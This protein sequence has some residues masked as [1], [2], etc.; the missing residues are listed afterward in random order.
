MPRR[1]GRVA[2]GPG[3]AKRFT[4]QRFAGESEDPREA[5]CW[6]LTLECGIR[7]TEAKLAWLED[8]IARIEK[9]EMPPVR[10]GKVTK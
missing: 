1:A 4:A 9:G 3:Q 6:F 8:V 5:W 10:K 7:M 2:E